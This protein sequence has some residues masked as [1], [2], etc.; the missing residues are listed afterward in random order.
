MFVQA[1]YLT[2]TVKP[3]LIINFLWLNQIPSH[4]KQRGLTYLYLD[5]NGEAL[6]VINQI[7]L[8]VWS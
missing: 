3:L 7:V 5:I 4:T 6:Q 1:T 8:L 2:Q